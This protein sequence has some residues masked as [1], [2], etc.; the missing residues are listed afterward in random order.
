MVHELTPVRSNR[1]I[2][3]SF[4]PGCTFCLLTSRSSWRLLVRSMD[5]PPSYS[6]PISFSLVN[7]HV[8]LGCV[9]LTRPYSLERGLR[10]CRNQNATHHISFP[11]RTRWEPASG[12]RYGC[13]RRCLA[14]RRAWPSKRDVFTSASHGPRHWTCHR[15]VDLVAYDVEMG[16]E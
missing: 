9:K 6:S 7:L 11:R 15:R 8:L 4:Q 12:S 5:V 16:G 10:F 3:S 14:R 13:T 1:P 2:G